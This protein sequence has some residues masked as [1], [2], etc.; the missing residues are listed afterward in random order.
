M[1]SLTI[2]TTPPFNLSKEKADSLIKTIED[3][4]VA[5]KVGQLFFLLHSEMLTQ[6]D[7]FQQL[8]TYKPGGLMFRP[9]TQSVIDEVIDEVMA[10]PADW[11]SRCASHSRGP[12]GRQ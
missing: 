9:T 2:L 1:N 12:S 6:Q 7:S 3:M 10:G 8:K 11:R 4:T 5:E